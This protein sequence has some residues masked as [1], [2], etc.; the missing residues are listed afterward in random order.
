MTQ[1]ETV[2]LAL[3]TLENVVQNSYLCLD[4]DVDRQRLVNLF[5][6]QFLRRIAEKETKN[7]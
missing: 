5:T 6:G 4:S 7:D 2:V 1:V 3:E